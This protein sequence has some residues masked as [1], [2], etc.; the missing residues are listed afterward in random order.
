M[1]PGSDF[2]P[3]GAVEDHP[4]RQVVGELLEAM[5]PVR[6]HEEHVPRPEGDSIVRRVRFTPDKELP[7]PAA[8]LLGAKKLVY[9]QENRWDKKANTMSWRA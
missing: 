9:E 4:H 3:H 8:K 1:E 5:G 6:R 2:A 7:G